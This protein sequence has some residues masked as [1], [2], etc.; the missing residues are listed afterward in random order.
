M[1]GTD[2]SSLISDSAPLSMD[3]ALVYP[4]REHWIAAIRSDMQSIVQRKPFKV[5]DTPPSCNLVSCKWMFELKSN[6][7]GQVVCYKA[8]LVARG[9]PQVRGTDYFEL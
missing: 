2:F 5:E 1:T 8:R 7:E 6:S 3:E 9:F 4:E